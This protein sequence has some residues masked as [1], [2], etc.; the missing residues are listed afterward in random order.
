MAG[1]GTSKGTSAERLYRSRTVLETPQ[2][3]VKDGLSR[4]RTE[5][6]KV[7][8]SCTQGM[9]FLAMDGVALM[10][11]EAV[12]RLTAVTMLGRLPI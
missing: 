12:V 5:T 10:P 1:N 7:E 6:R 4:V 9:P 2:G 11:V 3:V 8:A